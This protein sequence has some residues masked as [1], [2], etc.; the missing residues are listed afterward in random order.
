MWCSE[1]AHCACNALSQTAHYAV[2][3]KA[4]QGRPEVLL[5]LRKH[6]LKHKVYVFIN[7]IVVSPAR[8]LA[9]NGE[10]R[11]LLN[12]KV[13]I[14]SRKLCRSNPWPSLFF[15]W[16][17]AGE[18]HDCCLVE[19]IN[20]LSRASVNVW[21]KGMWRSGAIPDWNSFRFIF[22]ENHKFGLVSAEI[23]SNQIF[24]IV[25]S[26]VETS[27]IACRH[28]LVTCCVRMNLFCLPQKWMRIQ[29]KHF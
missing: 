12:L 24:C 22:I 14:V 17:R 20:I 7:A 11:S 16:W 4:L 5:I 9:K 2:L 21:W 3:P 28:D 1:H 25:E 19:N 10:G 23:R 6:L 18:K 15:A 27:N 26:E 29:M 13:R 8:H